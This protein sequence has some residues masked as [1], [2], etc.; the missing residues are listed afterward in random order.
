MAL[1]V[2]EGYFICNGALLILFISLCL[3]HRAF[4]RMF[5]RCVFELED[6]NRDAFEV[7]RV[8]H[9]FHK[10][11]KGWF[12][13]TSEVYSPYILVQL[14]FTVLM[15]ICLLFQLDLEL[16]HIDFNINIIL[17]TFA[18]SA[19]NLFIYCYFGKMATES[20]AQISDCLFESNWY[21]HPVNLQKHFILLIANAQTSLFYHGFGFT[22]LNLQTFNTM[23]RTVITYYMGLKTLTSK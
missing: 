22:V 19:S 8:I 20:Y 13:E 18:T 7:L 15:M 9:D 23:F 12:S 11:I 10:T 3:H 17:L 2:G 16:N 4:G 1:I 6:P 5:R 21:T 14:I